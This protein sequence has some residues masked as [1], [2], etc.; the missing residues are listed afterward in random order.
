[1]ETYQMLGGDKVGNAIEPGTEVAARSVDAN[2][3]SSPGDD[4]VAAHGNLELE[5]R[6]RCG[7]DH[8]GSA[9]LLCDAAHEPSGIQGVANIDLDQIRLPPLGLPLHFRL[10]MALCF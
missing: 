2:A 6:P 10:G 8:N 5:E 9:S 4:G 1:M 7:D 3:C